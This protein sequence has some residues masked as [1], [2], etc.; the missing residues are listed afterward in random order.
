MSKLSIYKTKSKKVKMNYSCHGTYKGIHLVFSLFSVKSIKK[1]TST[2]EQVQE[3]GVISPL[4]M[5]FDIRGGYSCIDVNQQVFGI[6]K[7]GLNIKH[8]W[9]ARDR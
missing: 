3:R 6:Y 5:V 2:Q 7:T 1:L 9:P 8:D 4:K